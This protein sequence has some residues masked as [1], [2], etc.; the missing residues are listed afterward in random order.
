MIGLYALKYPYRKILKPL[1][2]KMK[3]WNPDYLGYLATFVA[4]GTGICYFA[5]S[6]IPFLLIISIFLTFSE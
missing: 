3:H 6:K 1:A 2:Q 5:A 4:L